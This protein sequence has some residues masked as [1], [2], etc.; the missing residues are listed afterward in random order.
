[1][2]QRQKAALGK[3]LR[4][5][6]QLCRGPGIKLRGIK[7]PQGVSGEVPQVARGP[8]HILHDPLAMIGRGQS[9]E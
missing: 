7:I 9:E 6:A 5:V 4:Q 8:M 3:H 1:M 2:E